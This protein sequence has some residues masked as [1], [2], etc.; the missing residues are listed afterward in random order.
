[1]IGI[2]FAQTGGTSPAGTDL[3]MMMQ[4]IFPIILIIFV[5]YFLLI[6]P[7]QKKTREHQEFLS[8][9]KK[10]DEVVTSAGIHGKITGLTDVIA[11]LEIAEGVRIK[12]NRVSIQASAAEAK[13]QAETPAKTSGG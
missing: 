9:L 8:N 2:A 3:G 13:K 6:R 1:M 12:I 5:F 10:G 4:N 7:Q 11:T